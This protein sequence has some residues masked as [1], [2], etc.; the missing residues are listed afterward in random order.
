MTGCFFYEINQGFAGILFHFFSVYLGISPIF[1]A[2]FSH[3]V[4]GNREK[5]KRFEFWCGIR[6]GGKGLKIMVR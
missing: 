4:M 5:S 3:L 1:A 2:R 6:R